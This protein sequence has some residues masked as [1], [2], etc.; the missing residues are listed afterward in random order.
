MAYGDHHENFAV[1]QHRN[2]LPNDPYSPSPSPII[3]RRIDDESV[4]SS[5]YGKK[6]DYGYPAVTIDGEP[7]A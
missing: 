1:L 6:I 7:G 5:R 3:A 4:V 2:S